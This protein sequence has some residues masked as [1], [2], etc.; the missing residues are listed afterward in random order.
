MAYSKI[1]KDGTPAIISGQPKKVGID[2]FIRRTNDYLAECEKNKHIPLYQE[3]ALLLNIDPDTL[4]RYAK[5]PRYREVLKRVDK[6]TEVGLINKGLNENKPVFSM[7]LLKAK[8]GY[9]E[10]QYQKVD[11][12][13]SGLLAVVQMPAKK[14]KISS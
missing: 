10:S 7:F 12:N 5:T 3:L 11:L 13:V 8:H 2:D 1:K 9:I 4:T 14:P 6:L